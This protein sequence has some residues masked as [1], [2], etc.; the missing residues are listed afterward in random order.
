[1]GSKFR[2]KN[3]NSK[4]K[5]NKSK[6]KRHNGKSKPKQKQNQNKHSSRFLAKV[7]NQEA[8][9]RLKK[10]R[11]R[12]LEIQNQQSD[13]SEEE[14]VENP[15]NMLLSSFN[16]RE[17][18]DSK[19]CSSDEDSIG[20]DSDDDEN[21]DDEN[22]DDEELD[23]ED[24]S[25]ED[26]K[27]DNL[28]DNEDAEMHSDNDESDNKETQEKIDLP[29][30]ADATEDL[31]ASDNFSMHLDHEL[32]PELLNILSNKP[33]KSS[34]HE[35]T[36]PALG[37]LFVDIP[38]CDKP[39][40][41]T[42]KTLDDDVT[43]ATEGTKPER[44]DLNKLDWLKIGLKQQL[45]PHVVKEVTPLQ[46]ELF[47]IMN[48]YQDLYYP[49]RTLQ[50]GEEVRYTYCLHVLNHALKTR[51]KVLHHNSKI[52]QNK[53]EVPDRFRD[54]GFVRPRILIVVPFRDSALKIVKIL[55]NLLVPNRGGGV[56]N[57]LRFEQEYGGES[58][59]F[60]KHNPKPEDYEQLFTGNTDDTFKLGVAV[61]KKSIKLYADYYGSDIIIASPLGLRMSV[62]A[63]GES[64]RDYDFLSSVELLVMDQA[65]VFLAQ[66]W[67][68][69]LHTMEHMHLQ[70]KE[71]HD[72]D[73][74][75][76]R[77]WALNGHTRLYRQTILLSSHDIPQLR[78]FVRGR[79]SNY[80]GSVRVVN[81]VIGGSIRE[82]VVTLPQV[83]HRITCATAAEAIDARF[84]YFT[85]KVLGQYRSPAMAQCL[86]Y[87][88]DYF[89]YV[90]LRNYFKREEINF[91]QI[92]EYTKDSKMAR[93]RD[94][95]FHGIAP[96]ML[97]SERAHYFRRSRIKGIRHI[98]FYQPPGWPHFYSEMCNL[99]QEAN[100]NRKTGVDNNMT[101]TILFT[102]HDLLQVAGIVG[103]ERAGQLTHSNKDVHMFMTGD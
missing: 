99:M 29:G 11:M 38:T 27:D 64:H 89:D 31:P 20:S 26:N 44:I 61:T 94:M 85:K 45:I 4:H 1:M 80:R 93:A 5:P 103:T 54:Q 15:L 73:F 8:E 57:S 70:P 67:D 50:N 66:N 33:V 90:R 52:L 28:E 37:K 87:I 9:E 77:M 42:I 102:K 3:T 25:D 60:P 14:Q 81:P 74:A 51:T 2:G 62:G 83:F 96:I 88:P 82:V 43:Y 21:L 91:T 86:L 84:N 97:Y 53:N 65:D 7:Q 35:L 101:V 76:V 72:T 24:M 95:F 92:C 13:S 59:A 78:A 18:K 75:R 98:I 56:Q 23:D 69:I 16:N 41:K 39:V 48:N 55:T 46:S 10:Q 34:N 30:S 12:D 40:D 100:Q 36:W 32:S 79:C 47:S 17:V 19:A 6:F 68:H 71:S 22:L 63:P 49:N 58:I